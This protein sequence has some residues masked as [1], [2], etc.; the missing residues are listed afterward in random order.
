MLSQKE[1]KLKFFNVL[2]SSFP[3]TINKYT[4]YLYFSVLGQLFLD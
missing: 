3:N 1:S 2:S 4:I